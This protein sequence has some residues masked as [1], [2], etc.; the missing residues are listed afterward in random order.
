MHEEAGSR[1]CPR[2]PVPAGVCSGAKAG[3]L[4]D[5]LNGHVG[6]D[7]LPPAKRPVEFGIH[8]SSESPVPSP[9]TRLVSASLADRDPLLAPGKTSYPTHIS[10][11]LALQASSRQY[12]FFRDRAPFAW[13]VDTF[14][15]LFAFPRS[16]MASA[17]TTSSPKAP[18][19]DPA[20]ASTSNEPS[21]GLIAP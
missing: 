18:S 14:I 1:A 21:E 12:P 15:V 9:G 13:K 8:T 10:R 5:R 3:G 11:N 17:S 2:Q 20:T 7:Q 6:G 4:Q 16:F 19:E